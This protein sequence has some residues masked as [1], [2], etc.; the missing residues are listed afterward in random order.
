[1]DLQFQQMAT[2]MG[3]GISITRDDCEISF[4][5]LYPSS[6]SY[7]SVSCSSL[8]H[9]DRLG[10]ISLMTLCLFANLNIVD[11]MTEHGKHLGPQGEILEENFQAMMFGELWKYSRRQLNNVLAV[12]GDEQF[13]S[14]ILM[15]KINEMQTKSALAAILRASGGEDSPTQGGL[16]AKAD[17]FGMLEAKVDRMQ[18]SIDAILEKLDSKSS[19][20]PSIPSMGSSMTALGPMQFLRKRGHDEQDDGGGGGLFGG[21]NG[22]R[23]GSLPFASGLGSRAVRR[24]TLPHFGEWEA[25]ATSNSAGNDEEQSGGAAREVGREAVPVIAS[26]GEFDSKFS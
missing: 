25:Q 22:F 24:E 19:L 14:I 16:E 20:M 4:L 3:K 18:A 2:Q 9:A 23:A 7:N 6:F 5:E 1:M 13:R 21:L 11:L 17:R 12:S 26:A 8:T 15:L 10:I